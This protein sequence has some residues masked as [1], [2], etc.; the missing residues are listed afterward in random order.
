MC[1]LTFA[2]SGGTAFPGSWLL[3]HLQSHVVQLS[4]PAAFFPAPLTT[5]GEES[6][7][8]KDSHDDIGPIG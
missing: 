6:V 2:A 4:D 8:F 3:C 5:A 1:F 7:I